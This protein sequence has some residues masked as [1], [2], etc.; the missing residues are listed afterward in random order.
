MVDA[1]RQSG[2]TRR[3]Q[4]TDASTVTPRSASVW[5][6]AIALASL[7][8]ACG[9]DSGTGDLDLEWRSAF[10]AEAADSGWL[11]S[12]WG[13]SDDRR[14]AVGGESDRGV[15]LA[16][17]GS[18]WAE[19]DIPDVP[20]LNWVFG[21]GQ[22][23]VWAVGNGGNILHFD[24][25]DWTSET[26]PTT[27]DLWGVWGAEPDDLWAVGGSGRP[28]AEAVLLRYDG[29]D[30]SEVEVPEVEDAGVRALFKVWGSGAENV[31]VVGQSGLLLQYDGDAW[32]QHDLGVGEDLIAVWGT[33]PD[34]V[35]VVG[36]RASGVVG[37]YDGD[38][39]RSELL[40]GTPGINGV[41]MGS[42]GLAHLAV[43][44]GRIGVL[45][46]A[47][48][49]EP[50]LLNQETSLDFHGIYGTS[51]KLTAVGGNFNILPGNQ[52]LGIALER[53]LGPDD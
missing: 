3:R 6:C 17:D 1:F 42:E 20:L 28:D 10:D 43:A 38:E 40:I 46:V 27:E 8:P 39:W 45:E 4:L 49:D 14:Y 5:V 30:W 53:D 7:C 52:Q 12:T 26:S 51:G 18:D 11:L 16:F 19:S 22:D 48:L 32:Q 21:F 50:E 29:S 36:G 44:G 25:D 47:E 15:L 33:G 37:H 13:N 31:F 34:D 24:G 35:T 9:D 23:D 2:L 41:W